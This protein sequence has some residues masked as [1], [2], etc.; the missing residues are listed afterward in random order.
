MLNISVCILSGLL[1][2]FSFPPFK[3]WFLV[4][5]GMALAIHMIYTSGRLR[6]A[7]G[8]GYLILLAFNSSSVYWI[9]HWDGN[10]LFLKIGGAATV[11]AHPLF[12][13]IPLL[14]SYGIY[15][16]LKKEFAIYLFPL[17]WVGYEY[18][19]NTWQLSFPWLELG[20]TETYNLNRIQYADLAGVHG[21]TFVICVI[22]VV[23]YVL[24]IRLKGKT[25]K[26]VSAPSL[27]S[28]T[29][30]LILIIGP[31]IYSY[32]KLSSPENSAYYNTTDSSRLIRSTIIQPNVDPET[33]WALSKK[34]SL[35][36]AYIKHL[37]DALKTNADL[38]VLHE[39]ATPYYFFEDYN[40]YNT[41]KFLDF[42][43][44][45]RKYLL[46]GIPHIYYYPDSVKAP[47]DS[48]TSSITKR[49][50]GTFNSAAL[51]E[52]DKQIRDFTIHRKSKLVPFSERVPYQEYL[53]FL[54]KW[55]NWGVG[56][57]SWNRG[58]GLTLFNLNNPVFR[59]RA[60]FVTLICFESVFSDY[61]SE[62]VKN[63]A[64]FIVIITNDGWFGKSS[65]PVQHEQYAVLRA[66][67]NRKWIIRAA[68]TGISSYIDPL[69]KQYDETELNTEAVI[70]KTIIANDEKTFY[71]E[72]GDIIG[73]AGYYILIISL[74]LSLILYYA[75]NRKISKLA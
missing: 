12:M 64:E 27:I 31:Y 33:K 68:Q 7:F 13:L 8:R 37:N 38:Y 54:A 4:Y 72:H 24:I 9:G 53:P 41:K 70:S 42:V 14:A 73:K 67:E 28:I 30:V 62:G 23:L 65:G 71:T 3:T 75:V 61:V 49:K 5:P 16:A 17:I 69:G 50:F 45:N 63:G 15:K 34:D 19:D 57:S 32:N 39:T 51:L 43:N 11:M 46:I 55:I 40:Y 36:D 48:R 2:G 59:E 74:L 18:L 1:L 20:N 6:Q 60:K 52:P 29:L 66:I 26:I 44:Q 10:D 58:D 56:I 35:V 25:W 21:I 22:S 47:G